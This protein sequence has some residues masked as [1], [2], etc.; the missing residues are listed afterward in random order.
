MKRNAVKAVHANRLLRN[1]GEVEEFDAAIASL[2][3][4]ITGSQAADLVAAFDD[5]TKDAEVMFGLL[6]Y[7]EG[8]P[9]AVELEGLVRSLGD[10]ERR[11][12]WWGGT[13]VRRIRN[14]PSALPE[15]RRWLESLPPKIRERVDA[16]GDG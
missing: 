12:R 8:Q 9:L 10:L 15:F 6:H 3:P 5:S 16:L 11:G 7:L 14:D 1:R 13:L 4:V 2:P